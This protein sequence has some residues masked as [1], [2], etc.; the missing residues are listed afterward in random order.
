MLHKRLAKLFQDVDPKIQ[1]VVTRVIQAENAKLSYKQPQG[2]IEEVCQIIEE[3]V[4]N[5]TE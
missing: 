1:K 3:E 4:E 2:I 5:E